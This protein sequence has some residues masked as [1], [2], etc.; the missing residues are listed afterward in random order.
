MGHQTILLRDMYQKL[1]LAENQPYFLGNILA[2][3]D[4]EWRHWEEASSRISRS[5]RIYDQRLLPPL[6]DPAEPAG[7]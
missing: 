5:R 3:Y 7:K 2:R 6:I 4:Q 1:W